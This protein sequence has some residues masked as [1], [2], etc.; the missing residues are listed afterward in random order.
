M[1]YRYCILPEHYEIAKQNNISIELLNWRVRGGGWNVERATT[2]PPKQR[3]K[4]LDM[5]KANGIA[6]DTS[7]ARVRSGRNREES[8]TTPTMTRDAIV[9]LMADARR[10]G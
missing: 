5:A 7:H 2:T 3:T 10:K 4:W 9:R 6:P 8:A 1:N